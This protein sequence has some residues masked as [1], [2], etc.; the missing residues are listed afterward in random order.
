MNSHARYFTIFRVRPS[1]NAIFHA[2]SVVNLYLAISL[3]FI[4]CRA[5]FFRLETDLRLLA[6][7]Q[8]WEGLAVD[9][10][11]KALVLAQSQ[12]AT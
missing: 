4:D 10:R 2:V 12:S 9:L 11:M 1:F 5:P 3:L 6:A 7:R 8:V